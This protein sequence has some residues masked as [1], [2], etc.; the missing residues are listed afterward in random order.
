MRLKSNGNLDKFEK[1]SVSFHKKIRNSYLEL[2]K[3]EPNRFVIINGDQNI[4]TIQDEIH[5]ILD[6]LFS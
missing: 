5:S 3:K 1:E 6:K 4:N 2:A